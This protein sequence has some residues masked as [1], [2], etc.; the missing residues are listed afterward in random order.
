MVAAIPREI[1]DKIISDYQDDGVPV[2]AIGERHDVTRESVFNVLRRRG[3]PRRRRPGG[4]RK[5][6][7]SE[8]LRRIGEL[9]RASWSLTEL[10]DEFRTSNERI[11]RALDQLGLPK[12]MTRRDAKER[13]ITRGGY[14]AVVVPPD[15]PMR[16]MSWGSRSAYVLEHRLVMAR[17]LGRPLRPDETVHHINGDPLDNRLENL[18]LRQGNHG[19]GVVYTC[20][21]CG[22]HDVEARELT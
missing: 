3:V 22:S 11:M 4:K 14:A 20:R 19:K 9:R 16:V 21:A 1:E 8:E 17:S 7:S 5:E 13:I 10:A 2:R 6:F 12:R 15:D 18:Q